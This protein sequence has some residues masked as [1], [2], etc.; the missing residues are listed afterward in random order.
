MTQILNSA[1]RGD[2]HTPSTH[3]LNQRARASSVPCKPTPSEIARLRQGKRE[4]SQGAVGID[5]A[6]STSVRGRLLFSAA[7]IIFLIGLISE[8][9]TSLATRAPGHRTS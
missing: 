6:V 4:I 8:Q 7:V 5:D 3:L 1:G 9:I 2:S